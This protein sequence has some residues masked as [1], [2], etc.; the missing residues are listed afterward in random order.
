MRRARCMKDD[1][2]RI[3]QHAKSKRAE[4]QQHR[5]AQ[6]THHIARIQQSA[7]GFKQ[8][9]R[10]EK[11]QVT[12]LNLEN[13]SRCCST[14][15]CATSTTANKGT[16]ESRI[17]QMIHANLIHLLE[18]YRSDVQALLQSQGAKGNREAQLDDMEQDA[19]ARTFQEMRKISFNLL[20]LLALLQ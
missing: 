17:M 8:D 16:M 1:R 20:I 19:L 14:N 7:H 6:N 4:Q 18:R 12:S 10:V 2:Q 3:F 5:K 9:I 13:P 11:C 15:R